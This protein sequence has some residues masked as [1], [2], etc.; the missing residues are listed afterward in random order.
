MRFAALSASLIV[1]FVLG[2]CD[3][4]R[5]SSEGFRLPAGN[6]EAGATVYAAMNCSSCHGIQTEGEDAAPA[7]TKTLTLGGISSNLPSDGYL[8]TA[9][10]NPSHVIKLQPGIESTLPSG[11][12]RMLD[13]NDVLSVR[14]LVDLVAFLQTL[15]EF[16]TAYEGHGL[17]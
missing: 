14:Q 12:S 6:A 4:R 5:E 1:L 7:G 17:P 13:F 16:R 2:A 15:H 9:I 10:I 3:N 8:V 11:Q